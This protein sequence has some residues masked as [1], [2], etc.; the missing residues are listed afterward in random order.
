MHETFGTAVLQDG[1]DEPIERLPPPPV[2][3][4][5]LT[6]IAD[7][8]ERRLARLSGYER[9]RGNGRLLTRW[10]DV[11]PRVT[12]RGARSAF[13][14]DAA[15]GYHT[16]GLTAVMHELAPGCWQARHRHGGEAL[17]YVVSGRGH[18]EI[19]D[20]SYSWSEG[21]LVVVDHWCWHQHF[22]DDTRRT[23]RLIRVHNSDSLFNLMR[24]LLDPLELLEELPDLSDAPDLRGFQWPDVSEGRPGW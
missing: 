20:T 4:A 16:S 5:A 14:V 1:G 6:S 15:L 24:V 10:E 18:S 11:D 7:S 3:S 13:L 12:K 9:Q 8:Y 19:D 22:N 17:L 21:D 23:A 2:S